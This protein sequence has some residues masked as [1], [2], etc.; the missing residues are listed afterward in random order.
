MIC[1]FMKHPENTSMVQVHSWLWK[2]KLAKQFHL[3]GV[4]GLSTINTKQSLVDWVFSDTMELVMF[5]RLSTFRTFH[6]RW[7]KSYNLNLKR[8]RTW[9]LT[10]RTVK[11]TLKWV[12]FFW[13]RCCPWCF[14]MNNVLTKRRCYIF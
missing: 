14:Q 4:Q 12:L 1:N 13:K 3:V 9:K 7:L 10:S 2:Q 11:W 5:R 6:P 8:P